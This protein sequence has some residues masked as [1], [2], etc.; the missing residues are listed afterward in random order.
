MYLF[1]T[2]V[3]THIFKKRPSTKLLN[4]LARVAPDD[5][6]I[7]VI[8]VAEIVFGAQNSPRPAYHLENLHRLMAQVAVLDFDLNAAWLAGKIRAELERSATP[9]AWGDIQ[10]AAIA[11]CHDMTLITGNV[12]HFERIARLRMEN[13]M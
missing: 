2:D 1:D 10:I 6:H 12:G 3:I 7:S 8:T 4:H 9:L 13:W 11:K 5:Q